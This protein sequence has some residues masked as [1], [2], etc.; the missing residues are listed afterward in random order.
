MSFEKPWGNYLLEAIVETTAPQNISFWP[1]TIAWQLIFIVLAIL[2]IK[3]TYQTW[4][5]YQANAYRREALTWL[6]QCSLTNEDD[7][8]QLP[9]LLRKTALLAIKVN[10]HDENSLNGSLFINKRRQ[11]ITGLTGHSW[12]TWLDRQCKHSQFSRATLS[13]SQ[14]SLSNEVLLSQ[15]SYIPILDLHDSEFKSA[16]KQLCQQITL[17]VRHHQLLD[18]NL[19]HDLGKQA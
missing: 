16:L 19:Q 18:E 6:A 7:V 10:C 14:A 8:R 15:L 12:A 13:S 9:A 4:Q 1:Q 5:D 11:E 17:W 2:I 3:K